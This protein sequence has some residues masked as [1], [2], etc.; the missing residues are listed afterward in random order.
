M[1]DRS[2]K[3]LYD[4]FDRLCVPN[5]IEDVNLKVLIW[6]QEQINQNYYYY[7]YYYCYNYHQ[8]YSCVTIM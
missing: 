5:N 1:C 6:Y 7:Y 3:S 4:L 2:S 8:N